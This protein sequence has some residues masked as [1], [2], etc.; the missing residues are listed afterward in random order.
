MSENNQEAPLPEDEAP[1]LDGVEEA[2]LEVGE[3]V[4]EEFDMDPQDFEEEGD[5]DE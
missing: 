2:D 4:E 1:A 3:E 5:E